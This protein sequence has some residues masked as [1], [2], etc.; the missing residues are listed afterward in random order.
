MM[1]VRFDKACTRNEHEAAKVM[2]EDYRKRQRPQ[3]EIAAAMSCD[4]RFQN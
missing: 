3:K 2:L 4:G 1:N